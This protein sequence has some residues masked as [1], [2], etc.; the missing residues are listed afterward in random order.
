M[1]LPV[2]AIGVYELLAAG[3][4]ATGLGAFAVAKRHELAEGVAAAADVVA[5]TATDL[6]LQALP[7]I[8]SAATGVRPQGL[9]RHYDTVQDPIPVTGLDLD[10]DALKP[11]SPPILHI[12]ETHPT[13]VARPRPIPVPIDGGLT[14][15]PT[16]P[17]GPED[18]LSGLRRWTETAK[19]VGGQ[20]KDGAQRVAQNRWVQGAYTLYRWYNYGL[21]A[22]ATAEISRRMVV[23]GKDHG[24]V[25]YDYMYEPLFGKSDAVRTLLGGQQ[26]MAE[27]TTTGIL[28]VTLAKAVAPKW[29][30]P[31]M[32]A[33]KFVSQLPS[34]LSIHA[35]STLGN[36]SFIEHQMTA[37][38]TDAGN[39]DFDRATRTAGFFGFTS[40][41]YFPIKDW[42]INLPRFGR[43]GFREWWMRW[44]ARQMPTLQ[45]ALTSTDGA[46]W[47]GARLYHGAE[48]LVGPRVAAFFAPHY[49]PKLS[50]AVV[51]ALFATAYRNVTQAIASLPFFEDSDMQQS[52]WMTNARSA[53]STV[54][55]DPYLYLGAK[56][57]SVRSIFGNQ[58][59][60]MGL[61]YALNPYFSP[62]DG[63][64]V[65]VA[66]A[67]RVL[68]T[69][70]A[71]GMADLQKA[72][73]AK[74]LT[75]CNFSV[76]P[77][78]NLSA[79]TWAELTRQYTSHEV[80]SPVFVSA[81]VGT[82]RSHLGSHEMGTRRVGMALG[83]MLSQL[84][85]SPS[86]MSQGFLGWQAGLVGVLE[87]N[88]VRVAPR[89]A[90]RPLD[91]QEL[92]R[93]FQDI[94]DGHYDES[95]LF[96]FPRT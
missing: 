59:V 56:S 12:G 68:K 76:P 70:F 45:R 27:E 29:L 20:L 72:V 48:M 32:D 62:F 6:S 21:A 30:S 34:F 19:K 64:D 84:A 23:G 36:W 53:A 39:V 40:I 9:W 28:A 85:A 71:K 87:H 37:N 25:L 90:G 14:G 46:N 16:P 50:T 57:N 73:L 24:P 79:K 93:V 75:Q 74:P 49:I 3:A 1:V 92:D 60:F 54:L 47:L 86:E 91:T 94:N 8:V 96:Q 69:A 38:N 78:M 65:A 51:Y 18:P 7:W 52:L 11:W 13:P 55:F 80:L 15:S 58:V 26:L 42:L 4:A 89:H 67:D 35:Y 82:M 61:I 44:G 95:P 43:I 5:E 83:V 33:N 2:I 41:A 66:E 63:K 77:E 81:L 31:W 88:G 22:I 17:T 10:L